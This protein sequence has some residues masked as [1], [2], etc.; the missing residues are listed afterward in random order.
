MLVS[1]SPPALLPPQVP[2]HS[3]VAA[4]PNQLSSSS[5]LKEVHHPYHLTLVP[6]VGIAV[7]VISLMI[8]AVLIILIRKK[9]RE[10]EDSDTVDETFSKSKSFHHETGKPH[11]GTVKLPGL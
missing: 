11:E 7:S 3:S 2:P 9:R 6:G 1:G 10:L 5:T 8:L 4:G